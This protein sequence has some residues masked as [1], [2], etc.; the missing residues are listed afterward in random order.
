MYARRCV[1]L[2]VFC[3]HMFTTHT[4]TQ[5]VKN[6]DGEYVP[7][8]AVPEDDH[9]YF[10][11]PVQLLDIFAHLEERNLFLIQNVQETEEALEELKTQ[12]AEGKQEMEGKTKTV[13]ANIAELAKKLRQEDGKAANLAKRAAVNTLSADHRLLEKGLSTKIGHVYEDC[14]FDPETQTDSL[15]MLRELERWLEF[16][17]NAI[18]EYKKEDPTR[19]ADEEKVIKDKRRQEW[20][21]AVKMDVQRQ[22]EERKAKSTARAKAEIVRRSGKQVC[23][24]CVCAA[25]LFVCV[26]CACV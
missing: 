5:M 19:V 1:T 3:T 14:G 26:Y 25:H 13:E 24:P 18:E 8:E 11:D 17:L 10:K 16:L 22:A 4:H 12:F 9:M 15:E 6:E 7:A 21:K 20:R 23:S 2:F